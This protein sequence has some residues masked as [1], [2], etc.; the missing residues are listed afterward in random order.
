MGVY[1]QTWDDGVLI[2]PTAK[3]TRC[4]APHTHMFGI[5]EARRWK[6]TNPRQD[7][8]HGIQKSHT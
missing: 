2:R 4:A 7:V 6:W 3:R 8:A 5:M 1:A